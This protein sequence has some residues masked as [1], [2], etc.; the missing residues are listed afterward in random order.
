MKCEEFLCQAILWRGGFPKSASD[1]PITFTRGMIHGETLVAKKN[2]PNLSVVQDAVK[3][4]NF[5]KRVA[6]SIPV[7]LLIYVVK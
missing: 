1:T 3:I 5:I 7:F 4:I 6:H 2:S